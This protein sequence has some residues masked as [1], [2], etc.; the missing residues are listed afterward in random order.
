MHSLTLESKEETVANEPID[1]DSIESVD[2]EVLSQSQENSTDSIEKNSN[3]QT[4]GKCESVMPVENFDVV[5]GLKE[6]CSINNSNENNVKC[7]GLESASEDSSLSD[8]EKTLVDNS[9]VK[10]NS[11]YDIDKLCQKYSQSN[12]E[13]NYYFKSTFDTS[14]GTNSRKLIIF[15]ISVN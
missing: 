14:E 4:N 15:S 5:D 2:K 1:S 13:P 12:D 6:K 11:S 3:D 8:S 10:N 7:Q 9:S